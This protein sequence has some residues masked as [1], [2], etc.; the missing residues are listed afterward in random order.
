MKTVAGGANG[1]VT[2]RA[3]TTGT[4]GTSTLTVNEAV[5]TTPGGTAAGGS[6]ILE[7]GGAISLQSNGAVTST[8]TTA[9]A[10]G[11][12]FLHASSG[13]ITLE[14]A[15]TARGAGAGNGG[16]VTVLADS[17]KVLV[18]AGVDV[19]KGSSGADGT[20]QLKASGDITDDAN[21]NLVAN[22][23]GLVNAVSTGGKIVLDRNDAITTD[24]HSV[25]KVSLETSGTGGD[26]SI[27][28]H[29]ASALEVTT[30]TA[31]GA[32]S[33]PGG[34]AATSVGS[35][36]QGAKTVAGTSNGAVVIKSG[37][38][39]TV[40]QAIVTTPSGAGAVG[41]AVTLNS[42]GS[43]VSVGTVTTFGGA[44]TVSSSGSTILTGAT[45]DTSGST[46]GGNVTF[47]N[48]VVLLGAET[49]TTGGTG[50]GNITFSGTLD[51]TGAGAEALS[52]T[53]GTGNVVFTGAVGSGTRVGA[54]T[55]NS[56]TD[57]TAAA[58]KASSL[59]QSAG[60]GTTTL[61]GAV[62]TDALVGV[63]LT[64]ATIVVNSTITT[65]NSGVVTLNA[66]TGGLTI[67]AAGDIGADGAVSLTGGGTVKINTAG[68]VTTTNDNVTYNSDTTLAGAVA[69]GTNTGAGNINFS[70]KLD[71]TGEGAETLSLTAGT[72][73]VVFTGAVGSGMRV[74][75]ITINS[76]TD[77]TAV[78][79]K[80]SSLMQSAG[81]GTTTLNGAL[82]ANALAGMNLT[83]KVV[84]ING[85]VTTTNGG[86]VTLT[87]AGALSI[88]ADISAD[89]AITQNGAGVVSVGGAGS[90]SITTSADNVNFLRGV[91]LGVPLS[92]STAG[93]GAGAGDVTFQ[94]TLDGSQNLTVSAG[95]S[96]VLFSGAV[97]GT[98]RLGAIQITNAN[99]VTE[100][101]G[102]RAAS[103]VQSAGTGT[104]LLTGA[105][106]TDTAVGVQIASSNI[107]ASGGVT[108][109][110]G[111]VGVVTFSNSG[112]LTVSGVINADGDVT[113]NG[114]GTTLLNG[115]IVTS[116][117]LVQFH[118]PVLITGNRSIDT[119]AA[120][121]VGN[122]GAIQFLGS[123]NGG[124]NSLSL[125]A[126]GGSGNILFKGGVSNLVGLTVS[127]A[128]DFTL[129]TS[130]SMN[131]GSGGIGITTTGAI[132]VAGSVSTTSGGT[133]TL[134][135]GGALSIN[136][137][138]SSDGAITQNGAGAVSVGGA[139]TRSITTSADNV[140]FLRG[141]TLGVP[142]LI[143][144]VG[145][146]AGAGDVTFQSTL[147]GGQNLTVNAGS[148]N[149]L[150]S[151]AVGGTTRLGAI[152]ITNAHNVTESSGVTAVSVVQLAGTGTTLLTGVVDTDVMTGVNLTGN[153]ITV[154]GALTTRNGG[155]VTL[156]N[157]GALSINADISSDGAI[158]Q[159]GA[160]VV[161]V[162][163]TGTRSITT[164]ADNLNF[165]RGV[166][167]GVPLLINTAGTG[168]DS[169][170]VTFQSTLD[171]GQNL[172]VN[173]GSSNLLFTGAVGAAA[174]LGAI[175]ITNA[176][177]VTESSGVKAASLVQSAGTGATLLTGAV[178]TDVLTGVNLTGN[179]IT[180]N[181]T[182]TT[183]NGGTVTLTNAGA[184]SINADI[185]SDGAITQNG[186]GAVQITGGR[187]LVTTG[188]AI[189]FSRAVTVAGGSL[190]IDATNSGTQVLGA[191]IT[192]G[193]SIAGGGN[194]I[195]MNSGNA[196][197]LTL[198]GS[199]SGLGNFTVN[200]AGNVNVSAI[201]AS[202]LLSITGQA[203]AT[204]AGAVSANGPVT[205]AVND[206]D[207]QA[208]VDAS[209]NT[210]QIRPALATRSITVGSAEAGTLQL[211]SAELGRIASGGQ[212]T[213]G[214]VNHSG[215]IAIN[216]PVASPVNATGGLAFVNHT[217]GIAV[218]APITY[219]SGAG[220]LTLAANGN[221]THTGAITGN[222]SDL[223]T[224]RNL[225]LNAGSGI[226]T[227]SNPLHVQ[228]TSGTNVTAVNL[229]SAPGVTAGDISLLYTGA[230][231]FRLGGFN[232]AT[233]GGTIRV[234]VPNGS[235]DTGAARVSSQGSVNL[236]ANAV[237]ASAGN[238]AT[239]TVGTGG[240][241]AEGRILLRA[242][243]DLT[244]NG[245]VS[246][247]GGDVLM[248]A[249]N[250]S[251]MNPAANTGLQKVTGPAS[252][253]DGNCSTNALAS[254]VYAATESAYDTFGAVTLNAQVQAGTGDIVIAA[255]NKVSQPSTGT[256]GLI[257]S[258]GGSLVV[259]TFNDVSGGASIALG[260]GTA[261]GNQNGAGGVTLETRMSGDN[262]YSAAH[263][264]DF[265][266]SDIDYKSFGG[267]VIKGVGTAA[268]YV[269]IASSQ[270]IDL[271]ALGIQAKNLTLIAT[272]GDVVVNTQIKNSSINNGRD[273]GSMTL[274]A[275]NDIKV[276]WVPGT[277]DVTI[278]EAEPIELDGTRKTTTF[279]HALNLVS[280]GNI[281]FRGAAY[282]E[283]DLT[284]RAGASLAEAT[285]LGARMA[286]GSGTGGVILS[287]DPNASQPLEVKATNILI[288]GR[289]GT[290]EFPVSFVRLDASTGTVA[291]AVGRE[292]VRKD[293]QLIARDK[294][295]ILLGGTGGPGASE[296]RLTGGQ[297][298]GRSGAGQ[299]TKVS[300]VA[301]I[302]SQN[303]VIK[304]SDAYGS[305]DSSIVLQGGKASGDNRLGGGVVAFADSLLLAK[306]TKETDIG[307]GITLSG[308]ETTRF[309][310]AV[311]SAG[312]GIDPA[313]LNM[314]IGGNL[315]LQG[316]IGQ[317]T[318]ANIVNEGDI[319]IQI[320]GKAPHTYTS[321]TLGT[322]ATANGGLIIIGNGLS[323]GIFNG[324]N[325]ELDGNDLPV[326]ITFT[327]GGTINKIGD[328]GRGSAYIQTGVKLFDTSLLNY[329]I[330]AA[331]EETRTSRLR[332]GLTGG[333]DSNLPACN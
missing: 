18:N 108:T 234:E 92:I 299:V 183:G 110:S 102:I 58:L 163:G 215:P 274:L 233:V 199:V 43:T 322:Q 90:R 126:P 49:I 180:V 197:D 216:G 53:A 156:T 195:T 127:S 227:L 230:G 85:A 140:N 297:A 219:L 272:N 68:D 45:I 318:A 11:E 5:V 273:G 249:G 326:R 285:G 157:A 74:G 246:S 132:S 116:T 229:R 280:S 32:L 56:A 267:L 258:G 262:D 78:A 328:P 39:L 2:I 96:N 3:G 251:G 123:V 200:N 168:A 327:N 52:L 12:V 47:N 24:G 254:C 65:A 225:F 287:Y 21:G 106:N 301:A 240:I 295:E 302:E 201:S 243:D 164:S 312:V 177:N 212:L 239:I 158:T 298:S 228:N 19:S 307:G 69:I 223:L 333:D 143:N 86:A 94:S 60:S 145:T 13:D 245:T 316:G 87:N 203:N 211:T 296:L 149:V 175:Q 237:G 321:T 330:F 83:G 4:T 205:L 17:G 30:A 241:S 171:G 95:S 28:F 130:G 247:T 263:P 165:L 176:N 161:S 252:I 293:V 151:G 79:L 238:T 138:I 208:V 137:D 181:G 162:G 81:S 182:V 325:F 36:A 300:A 88:N 34:V 22:T 63:N 173:V 209:A 7:A 150:F 72:G 310:S 331:N 139:G 25:A 154:N 291:T 314:V 10:G 40:S 9:G 308:G 144:T 260:N 188:D 324:Q 73:N 62:D 289:S 320:G 135:N 306:T 41:G 185:S 93:T 61:N 323:S 259:R 292:T 255:T 236:L 315:V 202:G 147:D 82:N 129:D 141:V 59:V 222:G 277:N 332:A 174:R 303:M 166:T 26:R 50:A 91:T 290:T 8:G 305:N 288:G 242:A 170:D 217:G 124:G 253:P 14:K 125:A 134:T 265:G 75:A 29:E 112:T 270:N 121:T 115:D 190:N 304:G 172:M 281:E 105:I 89:G 319:T 133:V 77:V 136:A 100:S 206:L 48:N 84:T 146:G 142:L 6:V 35:R 187:N 51:G 282:V 329:L 226:G 191:P 120:P 64:A 309:G 152:Q 23:T 268:N 97:G 167:L 224:A 235:I 294:I 313:V 184:L 107:T 264:A 169:G 153:V 231:D 16:V 210:V 46:A 148:S 66:G 278:G 27:V 55:I 15:V 196:G 317:N 257:N 20:I 256:N 122:G 71:G 204:L 189:G 98:T 70:G 186:A 198:A 109:A 207:L 104:T 218:N 248:I 37:G 286:L 118:Q 284:L 33:T 221:G 103:L 261:G 131:L 220:N 67:A 38:A 111:S 271:N 114:S 178:D 194:H 54:I 80:A 279:N 214:G 266:A 244:V 232:N 31:T 159:N 128:R 283:G 269:G 192:F 311:V 113:V 57:V 44:V 213:V 117:D 76:A 155:A 275:K 160:G 193:S 101:A 119:T 250:S 276:N 99:N 1:A 42:T 179:V